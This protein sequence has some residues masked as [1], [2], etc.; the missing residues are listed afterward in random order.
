MLRNERK[1]NY[2]V[3]LDGK[4]N[5][6]YKNWTGIQMKCCPLVHPWHEI[7]SMLRMIIAL[8]PLLGHEPDEEDDYHHEQ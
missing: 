6:L 4:L 3:G 5:D 7:T 2:R 8:V 1:I